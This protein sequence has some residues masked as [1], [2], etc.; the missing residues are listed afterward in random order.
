MIETNQYANLS[1]SL[2]SQLWF[3]KND[4]IIIVWGINSA[5][6]TARKEKIVINAGF[7]FP[8]AVQRTV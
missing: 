1:E 5:N 3:L 2:S 4:W 8:T 6:L 7:N